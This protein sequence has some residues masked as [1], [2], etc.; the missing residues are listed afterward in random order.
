MKKLIAILV[1]AVI[2]VSIVPMAMAVDSPGHEGH[3]LTFVSGKPATCTTSGMGDGYFCNT[4]GGF[5]VHQKYIPAGHQYVD[6]VCTGCG[7]V[8]E[9]EVCDGTNHPNMETTIV[10]ATCY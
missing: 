1:V 3:E 2:V 9:Q 8:I 4:C 10:A 7:D 6:G 5:A